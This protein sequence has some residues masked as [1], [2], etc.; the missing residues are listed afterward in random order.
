MNFGI[1]A[2]GTGERLKEEGITAPKPMVEIAGKPLIRIIIDEA[3]RNGASSISIIINE[4][5]EEVEKYL[6]NLKLNIPL[7]IVVKSTPSSMHS[8][9]ALKKFLADESFILATTDSVFLPDEFRRFIKFVKINKAYD[10][11]LSVT[12][13]VEDEMPLSVS[14]DRSMIIRSFDD[15]INNNKYVT[16][17]L[18][19][20]S[21]VIFKEMDLALDSGINRLRN[22][23]RLLLFRGYLFRAYPFS[24]IIDVD[25][26]TDIQ[27]ANS[28]LTEAKLNL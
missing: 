28:L 25:H 9:F 23:L 14:V 7:N 4:E 11:I 6:N 24:I 10:G 17:G 5:S 16:G 18:Y 22:F 26:K 8:L 19:Y 1:I 12:D 27:K 20:F 2:A 13:Y 21:P 3:L 15:G